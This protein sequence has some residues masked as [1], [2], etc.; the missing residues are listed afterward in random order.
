M[1]GVYACEEWKLRLVGSNG[2]IKWGLLW[3]NVVAGCLWSLVKGFNCQFKFTYML[4]FN[5]EASTFVKCFF[6]HKLSSLHFPVIHIQIKI[7]TYIKLSIYSM[8]I[9]IYIIYYLYIYMYIYIYYIL[10][11]Y[12]YIYIYILQYANNAKS[13]QRESKS[14]QRLSFCCGMWTLIIWKKY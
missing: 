13:I 2:Y 8:I 10:F 11:I 3:L 5:S 4:E 9:Y 12:M 6:L 1:Q 7:H 14:L